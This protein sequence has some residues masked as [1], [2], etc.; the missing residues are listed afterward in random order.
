MQGVN[1]VVGSAGRP[2]DRAQRRIVSWAALDGQLGVN[3]NGGPRWGRIKV[4]LSAQNVLD[5]HPPLISDSQA[6]PVD[7]NYGS[8]NTSPV[9]RFVTLQLTQAW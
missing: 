9:G 8:T 4:T 5:R 2:S 3:V 1:R 6:G 7:V